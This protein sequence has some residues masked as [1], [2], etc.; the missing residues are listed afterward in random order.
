MTRRNQLRSRLHVCS[1]MF[2]HEQPK[3]S[4][5]ADGVP[6]ACSPPGTIRRAT[7]AASDRSARL[8]SG[9]TASEEF[10]AVHRPP[11]RGWAVSMTANL[12]GGG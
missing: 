4:L 9:F 11:G 3:S 7:I 6:T 10:V 8:A 1:D 2:G 5:C 12:A